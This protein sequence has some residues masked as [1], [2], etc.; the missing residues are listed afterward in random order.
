[1]KDKSS[2]L[3]VAFIIVGWNNL[4]LIDDC[5]ESILKQTYKPI[6]IIYVDNDSRDGSSKHVKEKYP[7]V[8]VIDSGANMGF[9]KG[10]NIGIKRALGDE[11]VRYV[12]LL[13][14]DARIA[15]D[16]VETIVHH[17]GY[18]P[19]GAAFQTITLDYY[20]HE[21]IDS[22]HLYLAQNG[23]GTQGSWRRPLLEGYDVAP[24]KVF[25]CNAAAVLYSRDFIES[26]PFEELFDDNMF[27]YLEDVDVAARATIMGWDNYVI[28]G[29]RAYHMGSAS[30]GKLPGYSLFMTYRNNIA[31]LAK[32]M[33]LSMF[34]RMIPGMM[35]SDYHTMKRLR[36]I[37]Q[38]K[39]IP[40]LIKGRLIGFARLP[41][42]TGKILKMRSYR[43][44]I[45]KQYLWRLMHK[46][47]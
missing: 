38:S 9:A 37:G 43:R 31:V 21:V 8:E 45:S 10:N 42:Y 44:S 15:D 17:A 7:E 12:A 1:M 13:N 5:I 34:I 35:R 23:Q 29:S 3:K 26:Q 25:G 46:G 19:R 36:H 27:M 18:K 40:Q 2:A 20:D 41:L 47:F 4:D 22:T 30:S 6:S 32:N 33:P 24:K 39:G 28:P 16:W 11:T 14:S